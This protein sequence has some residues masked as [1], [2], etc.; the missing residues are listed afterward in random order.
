M[1]EDGLLNDIIRARITSL[2]YGRVSK[3]DIEKLYIQEYEEIPP[4]FDIIESQN[5]GIGKKS[6]F[7]GTA[8]HFF[9]ENINEVY[10]INRG[11]EGNIDELTDG[12]YEKINIYRKDPEKLKEIVFDGNED[13]YTDIYTVLLGEDQS[14]GV[15]IFMCK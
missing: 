5:L 10:L 8:I 6:G 1:K 3:E 4:N 11:T 2:E 13:I 7:N 9:D 14:Q 12:L 15:S